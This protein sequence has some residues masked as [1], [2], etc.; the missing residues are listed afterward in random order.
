MTRSAESIGTD[1]LE[2]RV[3]EPR[4]R[5]EVAYLARTLNTMLDRI[6]R[7]V[8]EQRRLVADAS[9]ELRTPLAAMRSEIDVSLRT[10]DHPPAA[11]AILLSAR[12]EVDRLSRTVDDLLVLAAVDEGLALAAEPLE[13]GALAEAVIGRLRG[14]AE[15]ARVTVVHA[16]EPAIVLA[17][18]QRLE[19]ALRN[20]IENAIKFSPTGGTVTVRTRREGAIARVEVE[21][22]G[23]GIA[24]ADR[25]RVFERF[26]RADPS[27]TRTTGGSGLGLAITRE[28]VGAHGGA[29][30]AADGAR[31]ARLVVELPALGEASPDAPPAAPSAAG[32]HGGSRS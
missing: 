10:E 2:E 11:R 29:V 31:G 3:V 1:R 6:Q 26:F 32:S 8:E 22:E 7:G 21:D 18:E 13:L 15:Q 28:L 24:P 5:D 16:R 12:E 9:H 19:Q 17:D 23:P 25:E 27:R 20:V 4:T 14:V 30:C